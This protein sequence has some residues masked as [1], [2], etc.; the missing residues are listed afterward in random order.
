MPWEM[1]V[2]KAFSGSDAVLLEMS[3][4]FRGVRGAF[5]D[6]LLGEV[7]RD[8]GREEGRDEGREE[9]RENVGDPG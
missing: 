4:K 9:G 5:R 1:S 7:G 6:P 2:G 3:E 8:E